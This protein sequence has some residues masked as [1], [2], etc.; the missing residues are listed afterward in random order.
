MFERR[1]G[2]IFAGLTLGLASLGGCPAPDLVPVQIDDEAQVI[3]AGLTT[4]SFS[5]GK[6][7]L[8]E[9]RVPAD[10][11]LEIS[12]QPITGATLGLTR[13]SAPSGMVLN[14]QSRRA[15]A[16]SDRSLEVAPGVMGGGVGFRFVGTSAQTGAWQ[17]A[18]E[19]DPTQTLSELAAHA[20]ERASRRI[21]RCSRTS[22]SASPS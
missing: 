6:A 9:I 22:C 17:L 21:S 14:A 20:P 1:I 5:F 8:Y 19:A 3:E 15:K 2:T 11:G 16:S 4:G 10:Q 18:I 13:I 12:A 7:N